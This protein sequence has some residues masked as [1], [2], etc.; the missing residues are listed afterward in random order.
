VNAP[1]NAVFTFTAGTAVGWFELPGTGGGYGYGIS[2]QILRLLNYNGTVTAPCIQARYSTVQEGGNGN[3]K[4]MGTLWL[5][6]CLRF[7]RI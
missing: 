1:T 2:L 5:H 3:W 7:R 4:D 6:G